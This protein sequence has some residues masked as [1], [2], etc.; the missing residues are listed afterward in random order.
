MQIISVYTHEIVIDNNP[1]F[2]FYSIFQHFI[3]YLFFNI[4]FLTYF[5]TFYFLLIF[6]HFI[7]YL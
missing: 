2:L 6:Q 4:L 3:S 5:S 1:Y 7:S